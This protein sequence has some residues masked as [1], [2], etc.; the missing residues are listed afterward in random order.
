MT[1]IGGG[2]LGGSIM[3]LKNDGPTKVGGRVSSGVVQSLIGERYKRRRRA[4]YVICVNKCMKGV[5]GD[6]L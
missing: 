6:N 5:H 3:F 1:L 4:N 2:G